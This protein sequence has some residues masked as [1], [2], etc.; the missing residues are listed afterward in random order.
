MSEEVKKRRNYRSPRRAEQARETRRRILLA[1][2]GLFVEHGYASTTIATI[3]K[4]A[5]VAPETV[6]AA[7]GSKPALLQE[8]IGVAVRGD[9]DPQPLLERS[10][11]KAVREA[12]DQR[13]Q[14]R[15]FAADITTILE[16]VGPLFEV[17][18]GAAGA[19][20]DIAALHRN[21]VKARVRNL[22]VMVEW[23]AAKGPLRDGLT[24][25]TAA[26]TVNAITSPQVYGLLTRERGWSRRRF[27]AWL[28][29]T[30]EA[31]L[32][33]PGAG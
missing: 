25:E 5:G 1:A 7:F 6:Y 30:L 22:R 26:E 33:P 10:G 12:P 20:P 28:A 29:E 15:L 8:L 3:A 27:V 17:L 9:D 4:R 21:A 32:L 14:L 13:A 11:P 2:H 24:L 18:A 16:R 23:L 31:V 19:E